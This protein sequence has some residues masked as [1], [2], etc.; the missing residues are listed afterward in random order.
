MAFSYASNVSVVL[1]NHTSISKNMVNQGFECIALRVFSFCG[2]HNLRAQF[3]AI[4]KIY[5]RRMTKP[6][7][8][9]L[10]PIIILVVSSLLVLL[11]VVLRQNTAKI[12]YAITI[13]SL[14]ASIYVLFFG[15]PEF[16]LNLGK[17]TYYGL[18]FI[19]KKEFH[20]TSQIV[21]SDFTGG[22][23]TLNLIIALL[24][25]LVNYFLLIK[26]R[27]IMPIALLV[28]AACLL[29]FHSEN[30]VYLII[31]FE[32]VSF[33]IGYTFLREKQ[34][35]L[36]GFNL[37][38]SFMVF[39]SVSAIIMSTGKVTTSGIV[40]S[41][42]HSSNT[43]GLIVNPVMALSSL[44][45][46]LVLRIMFLLYSATKLSQASRLI[47]LMQL[48]LI[49]FLLLLNKNIFGGAHILLATQ[50]AVPALILTTCLILFILKKHQ[51]FSDQAA[52]LPFVFFL[53]CTFIVFV[54]K[55]NEAIL[56]VIL[57]L[58]LVCFVS[59]LIIQFLTSSTVEQEQE[60][61]IFKFILSLFF[62]MPLF[63]LQTYGAIF[64]LLKS[65]VESEKYLNLTFIG[66]NFITL[67]TFIFVKIISQLRNSKIQ[68]Q[69]A[70]KKEMIAK[71]FIIFCLVTI[72][73]LYSTNI[74][75][76]I[77]KTIKGF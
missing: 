2:K 69:S 26:N 43:T 25:T 23:S 65:L 21:T 64:Q 50:L 45:I 27:L 16:L 7:Y 67:L 76:Y 73:N 8:L 39:F 62:I 70:A 54:V 28:L 55:P 40:S 13:L 77:R 74:N 66:I 53:L 46:A 60:L 56:T 24:A 38:S 51:T 29:A 18:R 31:C 33:F 37:L 10:A 34:S 20:F 9:N 72:F 3:F 71:F 52:S 11:F 63:F 4:L 44:L 48:P 17:N 35:K 32:T 42:S 12:E 36:F 15:L 75:F 58:F 22:F 14:I 41:I 47:S 6:D 49:V 1:L 19:N 61:E 30:Y 59:N 57:E 5:R 68:F